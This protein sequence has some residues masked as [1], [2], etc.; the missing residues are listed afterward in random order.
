MTTKIPKLLT[1]REVADER[2]VTRQAISRAVREGRI[3]PAATLANG[4]HLFT[5]DQA[6]GEDEA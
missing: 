3:I 4:A 5:E 1:T 6:S 2:G